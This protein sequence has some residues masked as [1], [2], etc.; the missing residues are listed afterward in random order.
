MFP[1]KRIRF[2]WLILAVLCCPRLTA[3][4][5]FSA[6][7]LV[8]DAGKVV[9]GKIYVRDGQ[10]RQEFNDDEGQTVTIVRPDKKVVWVIIPRDRAYLELPLK[11]KLPGQFLQ[12]PPDALHK[13]QVG[14][15][16]LQG[17]ETDKY[18]LSVQGGSGLEQQTIWLAPKLGV[19]IKMECR[20]R[21]FSLEYTAIKEGKVA[22]R[23]F[24]LPPGYQ[25][26]G[27]YRGFVDKIEG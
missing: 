21:K 16:R 15:D 14:K 12:M 26:L 17:Y 22:D 7:M 24:E 20:E 23:L 3:A 9:T 8:K 4:A 5:E 1:I 11:P 6:L 27:S 13:R 2:W 25:K 10:M 18:E 19:P